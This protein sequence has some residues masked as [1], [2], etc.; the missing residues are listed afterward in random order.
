MPIRVNLKEYDFRDVV[1]L[2]ND[3]DQLPWE[4]Y[5]V[6]LTC[7][8]NIFVL[9]RNGDVIEVYEEQFTKERNMVKVVGGNEE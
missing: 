1:F 2:K 6:I 8:G 7:I 3:E 4:I 5:H 9:F